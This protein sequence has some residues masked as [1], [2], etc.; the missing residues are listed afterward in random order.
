MR[1]ILSTEI[2]TLSEDG[3]V[4]HC[5]RYVGGALVATFDCP[6]RTQDG[7]AGGRPRRRSAVRFESERERMKRKA[8]ADLQR[9]RQ[10]LADLTR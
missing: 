3:R 4:F 1:R 6:V 8:Q 2:H 10:M 7:K 9:A 5:E